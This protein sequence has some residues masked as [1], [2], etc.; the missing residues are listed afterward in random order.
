ML[1]NIKKKFTR[2]NSNPT[3]LISVSTHSIARRSILPLLNNPF[4]LLSPATHCSNI[5]ASFNTIFLINNSGSIV[6]RLW[7]KTRKALETIILIYTAY[8][9]NGIDIYFLNN[10]DSTHY[11]N[12]TTPATITKIFT[13]IHLMGG[14]PIKQRAKPKLINIIVITNGEASDD[15][16]SLI[17]AAAKKLDKYDALAYKEPGAKEYLK[18]LN[19]KLAA[20]EEDLRNIINIIPFTKN[21]GTKL[22]AN[23][24]LKVV[25][26]AVN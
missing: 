15:V 16:E 8:N 6:G 3:S 25:L 18:Q 4:S 2:K 19:N 12:I 22:T 20:G 11:C 24:I 13:S 1:S 10:P 26:S 5:N 7:Q 9:T 23:G 21:K 14:T 17:I